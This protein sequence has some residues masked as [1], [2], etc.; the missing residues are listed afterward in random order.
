MKL[1][2]I[3]FSVPVAGE[4]PRAAGG[5]RRVRARLLHHLRGGARQEAHVPGRQQARRRAVG[6]RPQG[7]QLRGAQVTAVGIDPRPR[8]A[9]SQMSFQREADQAADPAYATHRRRPAGGD[10]LR[11]QPHLLPAAVALSRGGLLV[12]VLLRL[13]RRRAGRPRPSSQG[14]AEEEQE[15]VHLPE[16]R[17]RELGEPQLAVGGGGVGCGRGGP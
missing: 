8:R 6:G 1:T 16:P 9:L 3:S 13:L 4:Q 2:R 11:E 15:Q 7:N 17:G 14:A 5:L 12:L 10:Q